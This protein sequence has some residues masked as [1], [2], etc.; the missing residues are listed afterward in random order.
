MSLF[1]NIRLHLLCLGMAVI[2]L[3]PRGINAHEIGKELEA[4]TNALISS[5]DENQANSL[6]FDFD[7]ELRKDWQFVPMDRKGLSFAQMKPHQRLLAMSLLQ[8]PLSHRGYS[9]SVQIMAMEQIL[10]ELENANPRRDPQKYHLFVFGKPSSTETWG[11]RIEGH[12]LSIS[13]TIVDGKTVVSTPAFFGTNPAEVREG[14]QQ[15]LRVLGREEDLGRKLVTLLSVEQKKTAI[16]SESAPPDIINGPGRDASPLEPAG[17]AASEM[18]EPQSA[19]L[20]ELIESYVGKLRYELATADMK[21][22]DDAG[23]DK[24]HFAWAGQLRVGKPHYYRVQ[25][26]TFILEYDNTQN[27]ANHVHC[28]WRDFKN[29]FGADLLKEHYQAQPHGGQ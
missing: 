10:H 29:D 24:I 23:F 13:F 18:N 5:L 1:V 27:G 19:I 12:H 4:A 20:R 28:V 9:Q 8:T 15:G 22:I 7:N 6:S 3:M 11:W 16:I 25:G 2:L 17:I 14:A 21:K 26:P